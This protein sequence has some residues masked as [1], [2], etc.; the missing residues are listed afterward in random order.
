VYALD[1]ADRGVTGYAGL[2]VALDA[3]EALGMGEACRR[4]VKLKQRERGPTETEWVQMFVMLRL[5][6]G[7]RVEDVNRLK[8][9]DGLRR[10]WPALE[11][12]S[13]RSALDFL[14]RFHDPT[15]QESV[16][17]RAVIRPPTPGLA[18][19]GRVN[20]AL[21]HTVQRAHPVS[22][23]TLDVDASIHACDKRAALRTYDGPR[24]YQPVAVYW[25]EQRLVVWDQFRDG[26]VPAGMGNKEVVTQALAALPSDVTTRYVRGDSALYEQRLMRT[27]DRGNVGFAISADLSRELRQEIERLPAD[28]W[29]PL[30][31]RDGSKGEPGRV[32]AEVPYVPDDPTARKGDRPYRYLAIRLPPKPVQLELFEPAPGPEYVA[33]VT[34]RPGSG[35]KLIHWHREKCGTVE[36]VHDWL[37]HDLGCRCFPSSAFGANAAWYRLGILA[38][39]LHQAMAWVALPKGW[40]RHRVRTVR[41]WLWTVAGRVVRHARRWVVVLSA[42]A[43]EALHVCVRA[44]EALAAVA[45]SGRTAWG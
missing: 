17:G 25:A 34:N 14:M 2:P 44:R 30:R 8:Q 16:P 20:E 43:G 39:N 26:N 6:G 4:E 18:A 36:H 23:A 33:V 1:R 42:L 21:V 7:E 38:L 9:D 11:G 41:W 29:R 31:A 45:R 37:K 13:A 35:P 40:E 12:M 22:T 32:W 5:A 3:F 15:Q 10:V 24:G 28:A 27:L 19:L